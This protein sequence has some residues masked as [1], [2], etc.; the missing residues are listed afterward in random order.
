MLEAQP[1]VGEG[2]KALGASPKPGGLLFLRR[3][4]VGQAHAHLTHL[5]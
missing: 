5:C 2:V 4:G 1:W 3:E